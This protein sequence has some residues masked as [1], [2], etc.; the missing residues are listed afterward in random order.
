MNTS[1]TVGS[2]RGRVWKKMAM[3]ILAIFC[4]L[5][6]SSLVAEDP[7]LEFFVVIPSYNNSKW[8]DK[9]LESVFSQTYQNWKLFYVDDHSSDNTGELVEQY[10]QARG[11]GKKCTI[12]NVSYT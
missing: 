1:P 6:T 12:P 7:P 8:Y 3:G 5:F 2:E 4:L 10:V 11:M 9:N